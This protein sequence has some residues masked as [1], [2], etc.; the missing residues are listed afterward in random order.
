V[1]IS[2]A[3][4]GAVLASVDSRL[5]LS[6]APSFLAGIRLLTLGLGLTLVILPYRA[7]FSALHQS[8]NTY[9]F[10]WEAYAAQLVAA[11][12]SATGIGCLVAAYYRE[13]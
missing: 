7:M 6:A 13:L 1:W 2:A 11:L 4:L 8:R 9:R 3:A 12:A 5:D 10:L